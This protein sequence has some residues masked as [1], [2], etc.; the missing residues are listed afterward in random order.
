VSEQEQKPRYPMINERTHTEKWQQ[1]KVP[2]SLKIMKWFDHLF[3]LYLLI[4]SDG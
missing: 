4:A 2:N 1:S 3:K